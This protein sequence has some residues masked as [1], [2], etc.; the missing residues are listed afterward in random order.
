M[1]TLL[2]TYLDYCEE[3]GDDACEGCPIGGGLDCPGVWRWREDKRLVTQ[4]DREQDR[5]Q[6]KERP[7]D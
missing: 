2:N 3:V 1:N 4:Q 6:G 5:E 7:N